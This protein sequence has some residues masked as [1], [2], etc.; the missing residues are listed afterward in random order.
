MVFDLLPQEDT[1]PIHIFD[2]N[3]LLLLDES[4]QYLEHLEKC[5]SQQNFKTI[6]HTRGQMGLRAARESEPDCILINTQLMDMDGIDLCRRI[7]D[8]SQTCGIP[9]IVMGKSTDDTLIQQARAAGCQFYV[10]K[11]IDPKTIIYLVNESI[12]DARSW[13]CD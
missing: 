8:D 11:P 5:F 12:A 6:S 1:D 9:V 4:R 7:V 13:I 3:C 2:Q 10:S